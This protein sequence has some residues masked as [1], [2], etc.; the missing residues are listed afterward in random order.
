MNIVRGIAAFVALLILGFIA[1]ITG[2]SPGV[3]A[4]GILLLVFAGALG[5]AAAGIYNLPALARTILGWAIV[6]CLVVIVWQGVGYRW[7][8]TV[9][10]AREERRAE[11]EA[12]KDSIAVATALATPIAECTAHPGVP[13]TMNAEWGQVIKSGRRPVSILFSGKT[14]WYLWPGIGPIPLEVFAP[15]MAQFAVPTG[16]TAPIHMKTVRAPR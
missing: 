11:K 2:G 13:C 16:E 15:G 9:T 4:A 3:L 10:P 1:W 12:R 8:T 5:A 6:L 7:T 14:E